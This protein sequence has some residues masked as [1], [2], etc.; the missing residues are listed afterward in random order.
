MRIAIAKLLLSAIAIL[1][2]DWLLPGVHVSGTWDAVLAAV[3]IAL[4][5][6]VVR[7]LLI[8]ITL[9]VTVVTLGLFLFVINAA[10]VLMASSWLRGFDVQGFWWALLFSFLLSLINSTMHGW[11]FPRQQPQQS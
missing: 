10:M 5:N 11:L 8:L 6:L 3:L 2:L 9:P 1:F 4:I 7:P